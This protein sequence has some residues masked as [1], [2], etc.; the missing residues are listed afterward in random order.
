MNNSSYFS[1]NKRILY[2]FK[3]ATLTIPV[4]TMPHTE[5]QL[6]DTITWAPRQVKETV[7]MNTYTIFDNDLSLI[8]L[9]NK[10]RPDIYNPHQIFLD[11][12]TPKT[13]NSR[14]GVSTSTSSPN[15]RRM[16]FTRGLKNVQ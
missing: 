3:N 5:I 9:M 13:K 8:S 16:V 2:Q 4:L 12:N 14:L 1:Y 10:A 6:L 7:D 11:L 15:N